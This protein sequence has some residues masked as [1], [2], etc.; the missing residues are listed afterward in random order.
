MNPFQH[1]VNQFQLHGDDIVFT[2]C[3]VIGFYLVARLLNVRPVIAL[4][5]AFMP[6]LFTLAMQD[7]GF[8]GLVVGAYS[9]LRFWN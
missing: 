5:F 3:V 6:I 4:A 9:R 2:V 1:L 7:P 8:R